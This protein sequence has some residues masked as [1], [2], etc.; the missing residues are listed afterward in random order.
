VT[1]VRTFYQDDRVRITSTA[2]YIDDSCYPLDELGEVWRARRSLAGRR[3]VIGLGVLVL[4]VLM[5]VA[6]SYVWWLGGLNRTVRRWLAGG[7]LGVVA[8][9]VVGLALAIIGVLLVET[10]LSAIEDIRGYGRNLELWASVNGHP[11]RLY[12]TN[13]ARRFGQICRALVRARAD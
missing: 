5:R 9:A 8:V 4:A 6:A 7:P 1:P 10:V 12:R 13:N 3:I 11:V 2:F